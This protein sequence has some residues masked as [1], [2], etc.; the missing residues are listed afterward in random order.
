MTNINTTIEI[1]GDP[2]E[3]FAFISDPS[4]NPKWQGG[5]VAAEVTSSGPLGVGSTYKQVAKML[6]REINSIFEIVAYEPGRLIKGRTVES[7]FPITFTRIVEPAKRPGYARVQAIVEGDAS[8]FFKLF[9]PLLDRMVK[10][11]VEGDYT[12]LKAL[13]EEKE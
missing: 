13:F 11:S 12:R 10:K 2:A 6:G 9:G 1:K 4:N 5:M 7:S 3:I 8:G